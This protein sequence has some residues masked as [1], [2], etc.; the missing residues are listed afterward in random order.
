MGRLSLTSSSFSPPHCSLSLGVKVVVRDALDETTPFDLPLSLVLGKM[1]QK[2]FELRSPQRNLLPLTF[3]NDI[4]V[5]T[6]LHR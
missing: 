3:P 4:T 6:A 2:V 5:A 1:P